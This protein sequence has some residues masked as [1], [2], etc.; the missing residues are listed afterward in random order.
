MK[1]KWMRLRLYKIIK[2]A[3]RISLCSDVTFGMPAVEAAQDG[4]PGKVPFRQVAYTGAKMSIPGYNF[5]VVL[6]LAGAVLSNTRPILLEHDRK[7]LAG[8]SSKCAIEAE[9]LVIEGHMLETA[10][11]G[12][13]LELANQGFQWQASVGA[14]PLAPPQ[15]IAAGARVDVNNQTVEGPCLV[16]SKW[17]LGESSFVKIG[18]DMATQSQFGQPIAASYNAGAYLPS[19]PTGQ[20]PSVHMLRNYNANESAIECALLRTINCGSQTEKQFSDEINS[21]ADSMRGITLHGVMARSIAAAGQTPLYE[22]VPLYTKSIEL[23]QASQNSTVSLPR[24]FAN[25]LNKA[26]LAQMNVMPTIYQRMVKTDSASDF[27]A[28]NFIRLSGVGGFQTVNAE[29]ELKSLRLLDA[30][31]SAKLST[32]GSILGLS[33]EQMVNDDVGAFAQL[34]EIFGRASALAIEQ[35]FHKVFLASFVAGNTIGLPPAGHPLNGVLT[36]LDL[37]PSNMNA[38]TWVLQYFRDQRDAQGM[39]MMAQPQTLFVPTSLEVPALQTMTAINATTPAGTNVLA[40][41][42]NVEVSP[43]LNNTSI[44]GNSQKDWYIVGNPN[45]LPFLILLFLNG[46]SSPTFESADM[47]FSVVGGMRWRGYWDFGFNAAEPQGA[48]KIDVT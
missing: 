22:R 25:T 11:A 7:A 39:P 10:A 37:S 23:I 24:V 38:L 31:Y 16:F 13:V 21:A 43:Y 32:F 41:R 33:R 44:A 6:N 17:Q 26:M 30:Q 46:A 8:Q 5:P 3:G 20:A 12:E 4:K 28:K 2:A 27:R 47:D 45:V 42:F 14:A 40:G 18:A 35:E 1:M 48:A 19:V 36:A 9:G 15:F 34:P 29:G